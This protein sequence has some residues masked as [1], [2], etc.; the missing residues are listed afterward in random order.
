MV[1]NQSQSVAERAAALYETELRKSLE[2]S[3]LNWFVAIEPESGEHFLGNTLS[4]AIQAA[5]AAHPRRISYAI[6][7]GHPTAIS[8]G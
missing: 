4:T 6:R 7:V 1:S 5:R 3:H 8:L 2:S